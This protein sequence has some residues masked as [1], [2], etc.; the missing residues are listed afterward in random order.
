[1]V[2]TLLISLLIFYVPAPIGGP[3]IPLGW[4]PA[5]VAALVCLHG[6]LCLTGLGVARMAYNSQTGAGNLRAHRVF[7]LMKLNVV[8]MLLLT[9]YLFRWPLFV[10][11]MFKP[12]S[13][14][15]VVDD[16]ALLLPALLMIVTVMVF[17]HS[18]ERGAGRMRLGRGEYVMLRVRTEL[19]ILLV[20]WLMLVLFGD[21]TRVL[22]GES[23]HYELIDTLVSVALVVG[24]ITFAPRLLRMV[25]QTT[26]LPAGPLRQR[27]EELCK[28]QGFR[29]SEILVWHTRNHIPNAGVIGMVPWLRYVLLTD[30]LLAHCSDEEV[31]SIFAHEMG[32]IKHHHLGFY[33]LFALG[34][35]CFYINAVDLLSRVGMVE[36]LGN[37]LGDELTVGQALIMLVFAALYWVF[38]F[39][40]LSRRLEQQA[41]LYSL[42]MSS[43]PTAFVTA[44]QKLS[45]LSGTPSGAGSWRHFSISHR[46]SFLR[47][48]MAHPERARRAE[49]AVR[50]VQLAVVMLFAISCARLLV[51]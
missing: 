44:L 33:L 50:L 36:P 30:A 49:R 40:F 43:E 27:L 20:P 34:F 14:L 11:W 18:F 16:L 4:V 35:M 22:F 25:W 15:P 23:P 19:A 24:V 12:V 47:Q 3:F 45:A 6:V 48:V 29:C 13:W 28:A 41:D 32:H 1:V 31:E 10:G 38:V 46:T 51:L 7:R 8:V 9:V 17:Q 42:R 37:V 39:G 5:G 26:P 21:L 2:L